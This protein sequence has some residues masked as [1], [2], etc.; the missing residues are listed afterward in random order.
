MRDPTAP[1]QR[2]ARAV[3]ASTMQEPSLVSRA[4]VFSKGRSNAMIAG[5]KSRGGRLSRQTTRGP[6]I[7]FEFRFVKR[8]LLAQRYDMST[9]MVSS[10]VQVQ[11]DASFSTRDTLIDA[12]RAWSAGNHDG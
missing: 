3:M 9:F 2:A 1:A 12:N 6:A 11:L 10:R 7:K 8:F 4:S 5:Y